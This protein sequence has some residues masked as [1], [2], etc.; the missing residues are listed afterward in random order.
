[1]TRM[2]VREGPPLEVLLRRLA[3]T[4]GDFLREPAIAG[5]P[6][7]RVEAVVHDLLAGL[8][9]AATE[10]GLAP[11]AGSG[12][13]DRNRL[14]VTLILAWLLA[15]EWFPEARPDPERVL[16]LLGEGSAELGAV[17]SGKF[18]ADPERREEMVRFALDR[19]GFRPA[20]ETPAQAA[21]R[22]SAVSSAERARVVAAARE[23]EKRA[24]QIREA[25]ARKAAQEAADK[26]SRE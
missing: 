18:V 3:E 13:K 12:P 11:F 26:A 19:L 10:A 14:A 23:A 2:S 21:D 22:L 6:G 25:L 24:R 15:D 9:A 20:G 4:P 1:M 8:G 17:A 7:L 5:G 16:A